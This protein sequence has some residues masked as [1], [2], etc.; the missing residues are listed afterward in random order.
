V[1]GPLNATS[2][3]PVTSAELAEA[4]GAVVN[5]PSWL[6]TPDFVLS[7]ALGEAAEIL[8]TGQ[9]VFPKKAVDLG[10]EFHHTKIVPALE[11]ILGDQ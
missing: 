10:Y 4:I 11:S 8:T 5:R 6:K 7:L 9:R 3:N 2:P 1:K